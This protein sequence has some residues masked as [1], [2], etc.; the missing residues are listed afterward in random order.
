MSSTED[1]PEGPVS[2]PCSTVELAQ[3]HHNAVQ[4]AVETLPHTSEVTT[5]DASSAPLPYRTRLFIVTMV[6]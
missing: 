2:P 4:G 1:S 3:A 5:L 6:A